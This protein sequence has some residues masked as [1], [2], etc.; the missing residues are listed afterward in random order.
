M[1]APGRATHLVGRARGVVAI[2]RAAIQAVILRASLVD[3]TIVV[4]IAAPVFIHAVANG[5]VAI[6]LPRPPGMS[7]HQQLILPIFPI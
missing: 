4:F 7:I 6:P 2:L 3:M 5:R 1:S